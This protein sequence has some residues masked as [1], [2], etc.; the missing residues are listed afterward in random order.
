MLK[1]ALHKI[2]TSAV[3]AYVIMFSLF[4]VSLQEAHRIDRRDIKRNCV[5]VVREWDTFQHLIEHATH[6]ASLA[7]RTQ[8]PEQRKAL[9]AYQQDLIDSVGPRPDC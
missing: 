4:F 5:S 9:D 3:T 8:T 2:V 7:G 6:P 1:R